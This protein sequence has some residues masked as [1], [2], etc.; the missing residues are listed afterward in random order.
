MTVTFR[1]NTSFPFLAIARRFDL[2]YATV[3]DF[4]ERV[5]LKQVSPYAGS[6]LQWVAA[7]RDAVASECE[8]RRLETFLDGACISRS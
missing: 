4:A 3:L 7:V 6:Q 5:E 1:P 8:R 2:P